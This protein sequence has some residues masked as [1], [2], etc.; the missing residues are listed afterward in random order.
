MVCVLFLVRI[1][2]LLTDWKFFLKPVAKLFLPFL[3]LV[4]HV[5]ESYRLIHFKCKMNNWTSIIISLNFYYALF[6]LFPPFTWVTLLG[7]KTFLQVF[8][9]YL[10]FFLMLWEVLSCFIIKTS[11][12]HIFN[13]FFLLLHY[14]LKCNYINL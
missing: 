2:W 11:L 14:H 8:G 12:E 9:K 6:A 1:A 10:G 13:Y 7:T 4:Y 5:C 3:W